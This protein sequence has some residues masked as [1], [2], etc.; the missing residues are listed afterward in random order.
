MSKRSR[1]TGK[2]LNC[3]DQVNAVSEDSRDGKMYSNSGYIHKVEP[4]GLN[5]YFIRICTMEKS[6]MIER[7]CCL[8]HKKMGPPS[9]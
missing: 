5:C 1:N 2:K 3:S 9:Y 4:A 7:Q 8:S 6:E